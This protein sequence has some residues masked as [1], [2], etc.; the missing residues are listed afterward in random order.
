[1]TAGFHKLRFDP[2]AEPVARRTESLRGVRAVPSLEQESEA[3]FANDEAAARFHLSSLF[4]R[5][6]RPTL[7]GMTAPERTELVPDLRLV[8]TQELPQTKTR[9]LHFQQTRRNVPVFGSKATCELNEARGLV[10]AEADIAEIPG[11]SPVPTVTQ[12]DAIQGI[13]E[14]AGVNA[15]TL[16]DVGAADLEYFRHPDTGEWHLAFHFHKVPAA[17][18]DLLLGAKGHGLGLS[19]RTVRPLVEYLVDAHDGAVIFYYSATP[20]LDLPVELA[21]VDE[22]DAQKKFLGRRIGDEF[23]LLDP[24]RDIAT[25][26]LQLG[27]IDHATLSDPF[28]APTATLGAQE[29]AVVSAH[30]NATTVS[31]FYRA[32]LSRDGINDKGMQLV[33]VV[34][35]TYPARE[36]PP[37]WHN[38]VWSDDRMWYGQA[39]DDQG[40]LVSFARFLDVIAHELTHGVTQ[41][42]S[43]LIYRGQ[44]GALNESFSDIFGIMVKNWD[45]SQQDGGDTAT[46]DW[47]LGAGLGDG[48]L[49]LR[50]LSD[51]TR[52][53]DPDHMANYLVTTSDSGGVHTNSNIHNKAAYEVLTAVDDSGHRVFSPREVAYLFYLCLTRLSSLADFSDAFSELLVVSGAFFSGDAAAKDRAEKA[54]RKAYTGVG[55]VEG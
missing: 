38:A 45:W 51:P 31:Q 46:W 49:P 20:L 42:S 26:D 8:G 7:R 54:I 37:S 34:N 3:G 39:P 1:M 28:R 2:Q 47:E 35:C 19:P 32:V 14:L 9:V 16:G 17:P 36:D 25:F 18:P 27:D 43:N 30:V 44:S 12:A 21:G 5:D 29:R 50:D 53:G 15:D 55:I 24:L 13:A 10:S 6:D 22:L 11:V 52:T 41:Y 33:N 23:E 40:R 4:E 48:G